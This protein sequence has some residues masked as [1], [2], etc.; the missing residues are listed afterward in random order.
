MSFLIRNAVMGAV[1]LAAGFS[2]EARAQAVVEDPGYCAQYYPNANCQNYGPGNPL[3]PGS[4]G[5]AGPPGAYAAPM[6]DRPYY[7]HR[8]HPRHHR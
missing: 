2:G 6:P 3:Y 5:P 7:P 1:L 4:Y 8:H